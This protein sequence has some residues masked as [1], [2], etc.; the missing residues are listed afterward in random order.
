MTHWTQIRLEDEQYARLV[1]ESEQSGL[2]LAELIRRAIDRTYGDGSTAERL[3]ALE[4]SFHARS[5]EIDSAEGMRRCVPDSAASWASRTPSEATRPRRHFDPH[6]SLRGL[7]AA[8]G[9]LTE[10]V[11]Q[12][13]SLI[14]SV[15]T[16]NE[17]L[18][19]F[20]RRRRPKPSAAGRAA[21]GSLRRCTRRTAGVP[22]PRYVR[23]C[24]H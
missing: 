15:L 19:G 22:A 7:Q 9:L 2:S 13:R 18:A 16:R 11:A 23:T 6:R 5:R 14:G 21:L 8:R 24:G 4:A 3:Q 17:V 10:A 1:A 12:Q 20:V